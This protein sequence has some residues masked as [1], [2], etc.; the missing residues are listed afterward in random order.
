MIG[1]MAMLAGATIEGAIAETGFNAEL[2][3]A[4]MAGLVTVAKVAGARVSE[5]KAS[6]RTIAG[7]RVLATLVGVIVEARRAVEIGVIL[8]GVAV[9]LTGVIIAEAILADASKV[10]I[11]AG[12]QVAVARAKASVAVA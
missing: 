9:M 7:A 10:A 5:S 2:Q 1:V 6:G 4:K 11:K 12:S 8:S 3:G